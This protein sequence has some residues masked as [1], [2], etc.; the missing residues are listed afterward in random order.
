MLISRDSNE[1]SLCTGRLP[2]L[3]LC[4]SVLIVCNR[5]RK[6]WI[7]KREQRTPLQLSRKEPDPQA[8]KSK[9]CSEIP[10]ERS[11]LFKR[12]AQK[13]R[14]RQP[15]NIKDAHGNHP[16]GDDRDELAIALH[17]MRKQD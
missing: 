17:V 14:L 3:E 7:A 15:E 9:D 8:A 2:L 13:F 16:C 12:A 5:L 4:G 6:F 11:G 10:Q 1:T